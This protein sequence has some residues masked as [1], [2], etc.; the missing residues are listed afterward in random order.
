MN[1]KIF[2]IISFLF[3][4]N[5][6]L[7]SQQGQFSDKR[8]LEITA[9]NYMASLAKLPETK[10]IGT[11]TKYINKSFKHSIVFISL[12]GKVEVSQTDYYGYLHILE[13]QT[14]DKLK[15]N[16]NKNHINNSHV[17]G[18]TGVVTFSSEFDKLSKNEVTEKGR[19][20]VTLTAKKINRRWRIIHT[21]SVQIELKKF[22]GNCFCEL[23]K[24]GSKQ[25]S[26]I[27]KLSA[28]EGENYRTHLDN[29]Y[30]FN[31]KGGKI[32]T[33][34]KKR[35]KWFNDN[36]VWVINNSN[37]KIV[38]LGKVS[39]L[40]NVIIIILKQNLYKGKCLNIVFDKK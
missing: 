32:I 18:E 36:S 37:E 25:K 6:N 11:V 27:T 22:K 3:F 30:F 7:L 38:R 40:K 31:V 35:Y 28:P 33:V 26:Y 39:V 24:S 5:L 9:N 16:I 10:D 14:K 19:F 21:S 12:K 15:T 1:W 20:L 8:D 29:F 13:Q 23:Y 4:K 17:V 2:L 34:K